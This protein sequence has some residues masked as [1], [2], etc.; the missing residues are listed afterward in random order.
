MWHSSEPTKVCGGEPSIFLT[1]GISKFYFY[2]WFGIT[3]SLLLIEENNY[4]FVW[5]FTMTFLCIYQEAY[6]FVNKR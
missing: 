3:W 2:E 5:L 4:N 1:F 6:G